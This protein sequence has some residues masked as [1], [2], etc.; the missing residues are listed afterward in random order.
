M[1]QQKAPGG[2]YFYVVLSDMSSERV[3][4][5]SSLWNTEVNWGAKPGKRTRLLQGWDHCGQEW[6]DWMD[7]ETVL[8][9]FSWH[10][11]WVIFPFCLW[12]KKG[13]LSRAVSPML[14]MNK[15]CGC[16]A[17][18]KWIWASPSTL[19]SLTAHLWTQISWSVLSFFPALPLPEV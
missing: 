3:K 16:F 7:L 2:L 12:V 11:S 4:L 9:P 6:V 15:V 19:I 8:S 13:M 14:P 1:K 17:I 5:S 18:T 10:I